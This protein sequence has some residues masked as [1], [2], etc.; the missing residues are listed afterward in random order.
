MSGLD[1]FECVYTAAVDA[2][3]E[4]PIGRTIGRL[5]E[6]CGRD[7]QQPSSKQFVRHVDTSSKAGAGVMCRKMPE[8]ALGLRQ[9]K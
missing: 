5:C 8:A 4:H 1:G 2:D 3:K 6:S 7:E 9:I